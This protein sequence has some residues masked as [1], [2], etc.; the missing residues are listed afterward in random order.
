MC[1]LQ[2]TCHKASKD[3]GF[4]SGNNNIEFNPFWKHNVRTHKILVLSS[5]FSPG[6]NTSYLIFNVEHKDHKRSSFKNSKQKLKQMCCQLT[7]G[8]LLKVVICFYLFKRAMWVPAYQKRNVDNKHSV[9][10]CSCK[11][12]RN[13]SLRP[14]VSFQQLKGLYDTQFFYHAFQLSLV[15]SK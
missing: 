9:C 1:N 3:K 5:L 12:F 15:A 2:T 4:V 13:M 10:T 11:Y 8:P 7:L 14:G 6:S